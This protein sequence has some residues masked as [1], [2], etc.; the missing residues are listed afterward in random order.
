MKTTLFVLSLCC[1]GMFCAPQTNAALPCTHHALTTAASSRAELEAKKRQ[2]MEYVEIIKDFNNSFAALLGILMMAE[3]KAT[4]DAVALI[5]DEYIS[6]DKYIATMAKAEALSETFGP[7]EGVK[8]GREL[9][10]NNMMT[11]EEAKEMLK[12]G[13]E[14]VRLISMLGER[15]EKLDELNYY[16]SEDLKNTVSTMLE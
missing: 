7:E 14:T 16:G 8:L 10:E 4:A 2:L 5:L 15:L 6:S 3:D 11:Q 13:K 12:L 1:G 9:A